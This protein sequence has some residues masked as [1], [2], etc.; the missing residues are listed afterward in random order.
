MWWSPRAAQPRTIDGEGRVKA[1]AEMGEPRFW[2]KLE[3]GSTRESSVPSV[4]KTLTVCADVPLRHELVLRLAINE[5]HKSSNLHC[6]HG[7]ML[8]HTRRPQ[9][10]RCSLIGIQRVIASDVP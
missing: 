5:W 8:V 3:Y 9:R 2:R 7:E 4:L 1:V 6:Q 10:V